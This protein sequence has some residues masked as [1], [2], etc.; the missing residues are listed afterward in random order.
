MSRI[1]AIEHLVDEILGVVQ[2]LLHVSKLRRMNDVMMARLGG[3]PREMP[4]R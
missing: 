2:K 4:L 3:D 1:D